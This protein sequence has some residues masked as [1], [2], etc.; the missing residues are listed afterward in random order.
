MCFDMNQGWL[1]KPEARPDIETAGYPLST[2]VNSESA[3]ESSRGATGLGCPPLN[4]I[5]R[6]CEAPVAREILPAK[7]PWESALDRMADPGPAACALH[8]GS[9]AQPRTG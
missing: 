7:T 5:E 8:C 9:R 1:W 3:R 4:I 6:S 2:S